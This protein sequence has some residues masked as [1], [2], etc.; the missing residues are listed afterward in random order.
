VIRRYRCRVTV[1]VLF[2]S[3]KVALS[4]EACDEL[5]RKLA[6]FGAPDAAERL[7]GHRSIRNEDKPVVREVLARWRRS[8]AATFPPDLNELH[9][10]LGL[11]LRRNGHRKP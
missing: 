1:E 10:R 2:G 7:L 9:A 6:L 5:A 8:A 3:G 4:D 11:D